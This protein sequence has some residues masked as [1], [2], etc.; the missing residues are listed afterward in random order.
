M[1]TEPLVSICCATY[2]HERFIGQAL[3][4]ILRQEVDFPIEI[5]VN[6]DASTD[7]TPAILREYEA[8]HP[9][10]IRVRYQAE[11]QYSQ[12]RRAFV[13]LLLPRVRGKYIALCEG[14]DYWTDPQKL[15]KQ[16]EFLEANPRFTLTCG[17][18]GV[19]VDGEAEGRVAPDL[20][21][22][23]GGAGEGGFAFGL[24]D[25]VDQWITKTLTAVFRT[26]ALPAAE[27]QRYR[28]VRDVH[29]YY[30]L[31][32]N[33]R[34]YY[35]CEELGVYRVHRGGVHSLASRTQRK[36]AAYDLYRELHGRNRDGFT[37]I[38][39]FHA[40]VAL[41]AHEVELGRAGSGVSRRLRLAA[42][43]LALVRSRQELHPLVG[44]LVP[45]H[46]GIRRWLGATHVPA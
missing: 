42:E 20:P 32:R 16:V 1:P 18:Y 19:E 43:A 9:E 25:M 41:I 3:D 11:N 14:D 29:V 15:R 4:G 28:H 31:V 34:G 21:A 45:L 6:D 36:N 24:E 37:R 7:G 17:G 5:L 12:G 35:F 33:G 40:T 10:L 22:R 30:H 46:S 26:D 44:A 39:A 27:V 23:C 38:K 13:H 8:R 2:N